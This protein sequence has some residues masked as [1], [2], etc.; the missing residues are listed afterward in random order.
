MQIQDHHLIGD[1]HTA[2]LVRDGCVNWLCLPAFDDPSVFASLLDSEGGR[3]DVHGQPRSTEYVD[4]TAI[5]KTRF[6]GYDVLDYMVPRPVQN[7]NMHVLERRIEANEDTT[8]SLLFNP[9][10]DHARSDVDLEVD[11]DKVSLPCG[12]GSIILHAPDNAEITRDVTSGVEIHVDIEAGER[13]TVCVEYYEDGCH[14]TEH[15][16]LTQTK[17]YWKEWI[18][19]GEFSSFCN[20]ELRRSAIT[21]KLMQ[22][23][24][25]GALV[26]APTTSLPEDIGGVRNWDYRY[27]W[28]RD[29]TFTL[30]G[31]YILGYEEEA[32]SFFSFIENIL[33]DTDVDDIEL[34]YTIRG[35]SV[36]DE[37]SLDFD[38]WKSS[39]PVRVGNGATHQFQLD[40]YG[41]LIDAYYFMWK[42]GL[43]LDEASKDVIERLAD[44]VEKHWEEPDAG[45]WEV[46]DGP[47]HFAY[48]KVTAWVGLDRAARIG[49]E[50]GFGT[51]SVWEDEA[52]TI[53]DWVWDNCYKDGKITQHPDSDA[54][55]ATS[56]LFV[57]FHFLQRGDARTADIISS[58]REELV[59]D[60]IFVYR[61]LAD[62]GLEG[63]EGAFVLCTYWMI[64]ALAR[65]HDAGEARQLFYEFES[66]LPDSGLIAEEIDGDTGEHL[67][68]FP[69][70]FS[71]LGY[72]MAANYIDRYADE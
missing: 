67:G 7:C 16:H 70:A 12:E 35:E 27:T 1:L 57:L 60:D 45:I 28:I 24:P 58:A 17:Q 63:D 55:D 61:Y 4:D 26:A 31:L 29:A 3:F 71:H 5:V 40:V 50:E 39:Q 68:N 13:K 41:T 15:D 34:M 9:R 48:S 44:A 43:D 30:Y 2:A 62:D 23:Y 32:K 19:K 69:Q 6:D 72:I 22:Y 33:E 66:Y 42:Q 54:Q 47:K 53:Q 25:S 20:A 11:G 64:A 52:Q 46:R 36:P 59:E 65:L 21:L 8:V 37:T 38:G 14:A 51:P 49:R 56:F 18:A 10:P